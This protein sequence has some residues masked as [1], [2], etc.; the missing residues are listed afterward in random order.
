MWDL[1]AYS[2]LD[3]ECPDTVNSSLGRQAQL[4]AGLERA[5]G[6]RGPSSLKPKR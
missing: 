5:C 4:C 2:Y 3:G 1:E 6:Q